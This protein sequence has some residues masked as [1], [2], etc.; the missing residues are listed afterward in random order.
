MMQYYQRHNLKLHLD[1]K[2]KGSV[3][4]AHI[5]YCCKPFSFQHISLGKRMQDYKNDHRGR[6]M[7]IPVPHFPLPE[8][9]LDMLTYVFF[10]FLYAL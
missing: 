3:F 7:N 6:M 10:G 5:C 4:T 9:K 1:T 8:L 2:Q